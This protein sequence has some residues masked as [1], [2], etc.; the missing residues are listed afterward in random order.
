MLKIGTS[1]PNEGTAP[2]PQSSPTISPTKPSLVEYFGLPLNFG[3]QDKYCN[4]PVLELKVG[5]WKKTTLFCG[6]IIAKLMYEERKFVWE[7]YHLQSILYTCFIL[8][9]E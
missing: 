3:D 4:I 5:T 9:D 2:S 6:E 7:V 8:I 1:Q